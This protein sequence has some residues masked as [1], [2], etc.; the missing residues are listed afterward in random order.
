MGMGEWM[1]LVQG[2]GMGKGEAKTE[3]ENA[4]GDAS[5]QQVDP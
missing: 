1:L 5:S 3:D 4:F 2:G